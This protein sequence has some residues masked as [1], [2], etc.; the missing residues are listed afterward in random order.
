MIEGCVSTKGDR[1]R[2]ANG[3]LK[4]QKATGKGGAASP[5]EHSDYVTTARGHC[6]S[7]TVPHLLRSLPDK[8]EPK[9]GTAVLHSMTSS[10]DSAPSSLKASSPGD[11]ACRH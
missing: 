9:P 5:I 10:R 6:C 11:A 8:L 2:E 4:Q 1:V 7:A 3:S